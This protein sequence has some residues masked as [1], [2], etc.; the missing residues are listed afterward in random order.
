MLTLV[1]LA[2]L[3]PVGFATKIY[4][5]PGAGWVRASLGGVLYVTFW[6]LVVFLWRPRWNAWGIV[7]G[8]LGATCLIEF[9]QLWH[10]A[11]LE[12]VR[13]YFVGRTILG[14]VFDW[15]DFPGYFA[16]AILGWFWLRGLKRVEA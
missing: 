7:A 2:V 11:W 15:W 5:G 16:G 14:N 4:A 10:P 8:V 1:S 9:A 13:G 3:V 12:W 6:S